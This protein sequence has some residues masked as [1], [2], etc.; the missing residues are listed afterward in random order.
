MNWLAWV[1]LLCGPFWDSTQF[2]NNRSSSPLGKRIMCIGVVIALSFSYI[3]FIDMLTNGHYF[4]AMVIAIS[5]LSLIVML[6]SM[7]N[8]Q[9]LKA[10][11]LLPYLGMSLLIATWGGVVPLTGGLFGIG[12]AIVTTGLDTILPVLLPYW[13]L[14]GIVYG[15]VLGLLTGSNWYRL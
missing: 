2:S 6:G 13:L 9:A 11:G 14:S 8:T 4:Q 10:Q 12:L 7:A 5:F 3:V 1:F 15:A